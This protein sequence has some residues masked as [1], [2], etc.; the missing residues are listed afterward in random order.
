MQY[1]TFEEIP[2]TASR[3]DLQQIYDAI[4]GARPCK[5][6]RNR[7]TAFAAIRKAMSGENGALASKSTA[8]RLS[9]AKAAP[10][11]KGESRAPAVP[12]EARQPREDSKKAKIIALLGRKS[13]ATLPELMEKL[14]W[15][16]H[17]VRGHI[18]SM[19]KQGY[20]SVISG[21]NTKGER[22]YKSV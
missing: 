18:S 17:T 22:V 3:S 7:D 1:A 16:P 20:F 4:P 5:R 8:K 11:A 14:N 9:K 15:L 21:K 10:K 19:Q 6:L 12:A 13:G 2:T